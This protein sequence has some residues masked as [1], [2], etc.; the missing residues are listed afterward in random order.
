MSFVAVVDDLK[1]ELEEFQEFASQPDEE[2]IVYKVPQSPGSDMLL[3]LKI[4]AL[5]DA[6]NGWR[7]VE[8]RR[9]K[10][11]PPS[12]G[13]GGG[14]DPWGGFGGGWGGGGDGWGGDVWA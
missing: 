14:G 5:E 1:D 7:L 13:A 4:I 2:T 11:C 10:K 6:P 12:S 8:F 3:E 9:Y